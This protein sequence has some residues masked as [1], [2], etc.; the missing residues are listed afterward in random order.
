LKQF[1]TYLF[2]FAALNT[3]QGQFYLRG[4]VTDDKKTPISNARILVYSQK[5]YYYSGAGNGSFGIS[6]KN[7]TDS[8]LIN[9]EGYEPLTVFV[10]CNEWQNIIL[11]SLESSAAR[12]V[13]KLASLANNL[14]YTA[15]GPVFENDETYFQIVENKFIPTVQFPLSGFSLNV[16]KASYSNVRRFINQKSL[17]PPDAVRVEEMVNYFNLR[18][19]PPKDNADFNIQTAQTTCPWNKDDHLL[20]INV[21]A[22]EIDLD[23]IPPGNFVFL[24]DVSGSMDMPNRLPLLKEA[25]QLFV[26]NLRPQDRVSIV[27]YGGFVQVW[28]PSTSGD[29]KAKILESIESLVAEG[30]T[31]G[32][33]AIRLAYKVARSSFLPEGNNRIIMATDGDF[34][35]G[36]NS[37]KGLDELISKQSQTGIYLTCLGVGM[38]NLKDSKL[39]VLAKKGNGNYA[40][41]DNSSEAERVL[42]KELTRTLYSAADDA[43]ININFN[44]DAVEQYRLIGFDNKKAAL[45]KTNNELEGGEIGSGSSIMAVYQIKTKPEQNHIS[46]NDEKLL[47][48]LQLK[49]R[50]L[51]DT[52]FVSQWINVSSSCIPFD[53]AEKEIRL[54]AAVSLFGMKIRQSTFVQN[55]T[56]KQIQEM[57]EKSVNQQNYLQRELL[58]LL[59]KAKK[60]YPD[61]KSRKK[62]KLFSF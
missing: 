6:I 53:S 18:Y 60:L 9:A 59:E 4:Q 55:I 25:F 33:S 40:Y 36:E 51:R 30:D 19:Q 52:A 46:S 42:V 34:N 35:V 47:A 5:A 15:S 54:A 7:A 3:A 12:P 14:E 58:L 24:I 39:Q 11:K 13:S 57:A 32:E 17:V 48:R 22:K 45:S 62:K 61:R 31:P 37:E 29:Q 10:N 26:K 50:K 41:L 27:T 1:F 38:G 49:Y 20:F 16:N 28:L 8:L 44:A 23:Q 2:F 21:S 43:S 56:W